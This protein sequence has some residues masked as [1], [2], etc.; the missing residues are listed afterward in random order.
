MRTPS[1]RALVALSVAVAL[2]AGAAG[3]AVAAGPG[4]GR[5]GKAGK[6]AVVKQRALHGI[7]KVVSDYVGLSPKELR[8]QL[9]SGKSLA[10]VATAQGKTVDG[11]KQAIL[12]AAKTRLDKAVANGR[13]TAERE[14]KLLERLAV[15]VDKLVNRVHPARA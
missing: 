14:Q 8:E 4:K 5:P 1:K 3:S 9:R 6:T 13:L 2:G 7:V 15:Q 12:T 10:Q 11:L